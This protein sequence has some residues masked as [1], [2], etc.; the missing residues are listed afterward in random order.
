MFSIISRRCLN[1]TLRY[2]PF[3]YQVSTKHA[4]T[5][6]KKVVTNTICNSK[7]QIFSYNQ[8]RSLTLDEWAEIGKK[9]ETPD[10]LTPQKLIERVMRVV[11]DFDK[12]KEAAKTEVTE[13]THFMNDL[14][15]DSL[16]HV[17]IIVALEDEFGFEIADVDYDKLYTPRAIVEYMIQKLHINTSP[18]PLPSSDSDPRHNIPH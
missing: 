1:I 5:L 15:L 8:N 17:E 7:L 10:A 6:S 16:D 13:T 18:P 2:C 3:A 9:F 4:H 14:G 12:V 11:N